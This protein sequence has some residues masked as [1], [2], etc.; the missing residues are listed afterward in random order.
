MK[1]RNLDVHSNRGP[2]P[3]ACLLLTICLIAGWPTLAADKETLTTASDPHYTEAGFFDVHVCNWP[4]RPL[5]FMTLFSTPRYAELQ[6]VEVFQPDG[7]PLG[8]ISLKHYRLLKRKNKPDK[9]VFMVQIDVPEGAK[10]GWYT[11][12]A[13][14]SDGTK[15]QAHDYVVIETMQLASGLNPAPDAENVPVP[16]VLSWDPVPG[17]SYYQVF[18]RDMWDDGKT[19][20]T[21]KL[22]SEPRIELPK[23]LLGPGGE[24]RWRVNARDTNENVILG[25]FNHGSLTGE[26]SFSTADE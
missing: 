11:A 24:Y 26:F 18:I 1:E 12:Y 16:K 3:A 21:S 20:L 2:H 23:G 10:E 7:Q 19:I 15:Y 14:L 6:K 9:R 8:E 22:L 25:D 5:F 13:T 17:A 4:N